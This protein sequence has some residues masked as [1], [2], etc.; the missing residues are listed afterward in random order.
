MAEQTN[1]IKIEDAATLSIVHGFNKLE[2]EMRVR[3]A[4]IQKESQAQWDAY[5]KEVTEERNRLLE[6]LR[7]SVGQPDISNY[8]INADYLEVGIAFLEQREEEK[9]DDNGECQG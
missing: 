8:V 2:T 3:H 7:F 6:R 1:I 4:E 9:E 5:M